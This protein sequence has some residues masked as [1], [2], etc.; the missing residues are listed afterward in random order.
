MMSSWCRAEE[1]WFNHG[2]IFPDGFHSKVNFRSSLVLDQLCIHECSVIGQGGEFWPQPTFRVAAM[3]RPQEPLVAKSCTGCWSGVS[4]SHSHTSLSQ[5]RCSTK[6][7]CNDVLG[8]IPI[9]GMAIVFKQFKAGSQ[10]SQDL[11]R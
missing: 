5:L 8:W 2:Y 1:G 6:L 4:I 3:D 10:D 11:L 7:L 9:K